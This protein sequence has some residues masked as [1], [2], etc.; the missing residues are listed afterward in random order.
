MT[1][2]VISCEGS[3]L[4]NVYT[5]DEVSNRISKVTTVTGDIAKIA[6]AGTG[7]SNA[8][9]GYEVE[10]TE[11]TTTYTYNI[12]NQL[13]GETTAEGSISYEYDTNGNLVKQSGKKDVTYVYDKENHLIQA[14]IRKGNAVTTESYTY[15]YAGNRKAKEV[16]EGGKTCYV[17]DESSGLARVVAETDETGNVKSLYTLNGS[18]RISMERDGKTGYYFHDGHGSVRGL[19][20]ENGTITDRYSYDAY[21]NLLKAEGNTENDF[22]YTGEQY[23]A[24]TGLYYLR[25]RYMNPSTGTFISMDSYA[26]N[27]YDPVS[28]HKYLYANANPV[29]NTDPTGYFSL[30]D[31]STATSIR[32][33][34]NAMHSCMNLQKIIRWANALCTIYDTTM[35]IRNVI[36]GNGT[37]GDVMVALLQGVVVG[38]MVD[39]MCKTSL[40]IILKPMMALFGLAGQ[41]DQIQEA[42]ESGDPLEISVRF[43]QLICMLFGLT[44]Q[45]FTGETLVST[46]TG[47]IPIADIKEGDYVWTENVETG[48]KELKQVLKVYVSETDTIV[49]VNLRDENGDE[50][51]VINTTEQHPFYVEGKGWT[52]AA[53][54]EEGDKLRGKGGKCK[55]VEG[56]AVEKSDNF[57]KVYNLE[58]ADAHTYYVSDNEVLVHNT[59]TNQN[60]R[61][62]GAAHRSETA[63]I[64]SEITGRNNKFDTEV[65]YKYTDSD[66][67]KRYRFADLVEIVKGDIVKIYQI[68][69]SNKDGTPVIRERRAIRDILSSLKDAELIDVIVEFI[70]YNG[71]NNYEYTVDDIFD[72]NL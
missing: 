11:G 17:L 18:E 29:M 4:T 23:N 55:T 20:D 48:E 61:R 60:G 47:L 21:G 13:T 1:K 62:G 14:V 45:C 36:L 43:V 25:A 64:E 32:S 27:T 16:N 26:G 10:I 52:T 72:L 57:V 58:V 15:D 42:I 41:V 24:N 44:S 68:G 3:S 54:L 56:V 49:H 19:T 9:S 38:F 63:R 30:A 59:C 51:T 5:Y 50:I 6:D 34:L 35:E 66:G 71:G 22:L 12:L 53:V 31:T 8:A 65:G 46:E 39:G 28:L 70:S 33:T 67:D 69:K 37:V 40:G 2:E 7:S